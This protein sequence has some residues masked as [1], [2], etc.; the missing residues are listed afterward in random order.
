MQTVG[1]ITGTLAGLR[2]GVPMLGGSGELERRIANDEIRCCADDDLALRYIRFL[3]AERDDV[4]SVLSA[5]R[6][7]AMGVEGGPTSV[8]SLS[9][10]ACQPNRGAKLPCPSW[11]EHLIFLPLACP[12]TSLAPEP[13]KSARHRK[14]A[15]LPPWPVPAPVW[16]Y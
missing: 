11:I 4:L 12:P 2:A 3:I 1:G 6:I 13:W 8:S 14:R 7:R 9:V 15:I 16:S 10:F 5:Q